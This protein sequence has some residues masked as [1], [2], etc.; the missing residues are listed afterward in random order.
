MLIL[1]D[2]N[3]E[4]AIKSNSF[5][6][7]YFSA[8]W[9]GPCKAYGPIVEK[10]AEKHNDITFGK[11]DCDENSESTIKYGIRSIPCTLFIK[12]GEVIEKGIGALTEKQVE[13]IINNINNK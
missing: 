3:L 10:M 8:E 13:E 12:N 11:I 7:A 5:V 6:V 1:N 2:K 4:E 9:C